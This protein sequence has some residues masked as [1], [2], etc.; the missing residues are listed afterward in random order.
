MSFSWANHLKKTEKKLI[1]RYN[2]LS[3][4]N[5]DFRIRH[6]NLAKEAETN[7]TDVELKKYVQLEMLR[8]LKYGK[9]PKPSLIVKRLNRVV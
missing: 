4:T 8:K 3:K 7:Q 1:Y 5:V 6:P 2:I 9:V